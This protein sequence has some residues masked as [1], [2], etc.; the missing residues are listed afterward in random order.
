VARIHIRK[1]H[2]LDR[3]TI[4]ARVEELA[5][6]FAEE[7]AAECHWR[8]ERMEFERS[9]ASGFIAV[10]ES[11][12]EIEVRLGMLLSPLRS[13]IEGSIESYLD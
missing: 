9:G 11:S 2:Q 7:L 3:E 10:G 1:R 8:G 6:K 12:L 5:D 13:K 4:L